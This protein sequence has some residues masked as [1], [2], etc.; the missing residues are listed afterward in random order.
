MHRREKEKKFDLQDR[1]SFLVVAPGD[2]FRQRFR[3]D[4]SVVPGT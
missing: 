1:S 2:V 3:A 4:R